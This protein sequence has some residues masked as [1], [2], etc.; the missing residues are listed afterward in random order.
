MYIFKLAHVQ[1]FK[2][3]IFTFLFIFML[4]CGQAG[5]KL[6]T[7]SFIVASWPKRQY[8]ER[9]VSDLHHISDPETL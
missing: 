5:K 9:A 6:D 3:Y 4:L 1:F 7:V 8:S 2:Y